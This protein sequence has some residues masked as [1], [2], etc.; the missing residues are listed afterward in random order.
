MEKGYIT[1]ESRLPE[2]ILMPDHLKKIYITQT[3]KLLYCVLLDRTMKEKNEDEK[4]HL[5]IEWRIEDQAME[6]LKS[7]ATIKRSLFELELMG[8]IKRERKNVGKA[9]RIYVLL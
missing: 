6:L 9:A 2:G 5:Y 7:E 1:K 4:G 3:S 8:L